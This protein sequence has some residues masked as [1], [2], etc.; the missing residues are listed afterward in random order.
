MAIRPPPNSAAAPRCGVSQLSF[1]LAPC[2][3]TPIPDQPSS[4]PTGERRENI[5]LD[6]DAEL[7]AASFPSSAS[8]GDAVYFEG[9]AV[10]P[11]VYV[12]EEGVEIEITEDHLD[13]IAARLPDVQVIR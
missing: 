3:V 8:N 11:G 13:A 1:S 2:S 7:S 6:V 4:E 5:Q 9:V 12:A 10:T